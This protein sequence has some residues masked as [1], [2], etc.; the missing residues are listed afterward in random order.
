MIA[1]V[2]KPPPGEA[3]TNL[4]NAGIYVMEPEVLDRIPSGR[5][6]VRGAR[7]VSRPSQRKGRSTRLS[8]GAYWLDTGTPEAYL[9]AHRDLLEGRRGEP[10]GA[11]RERSALRRMGAGRSVGRRLRRPRFP[12]GRRRI[13]GTRRD[14]HRIRRRRGLHSGERGER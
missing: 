9:R 12:R 5:R 1:F 2:E 7:D 13:G 3:S 8:D 6:S 11:R 10:P 4:I 14:R